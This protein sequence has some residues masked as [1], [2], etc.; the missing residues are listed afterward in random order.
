VW[1]VCGLDV[2]VANSSPELDRKAPRRSL[3]LLA[4]IILCSPVQPEVSWRNVR[5]TDLPALF[6]DHEL[7][8][9]VHYAYQF[10]ADGTF[11]GFNMGKPVQGSW[12]VSGDEFCWTQKRRAATEECFEVERSGGYIHL[13]RDGYQ[14]LA[15]KLTPP[16]LQPKAEAPR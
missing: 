13:V 9:G 15:A 16:K 6:A 8:D 5:G 14:V 10:R 3:L 11:T 7:A 12:R 1:G 2:P 4:L